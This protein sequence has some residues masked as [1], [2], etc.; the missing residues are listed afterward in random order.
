[1]ADLSLQTTI[2]IEQLYSLLMQLPAKKKLEI[3]RI[4]RAQAVGERWALLSE[5]LPD[6]S[7]E[8]S[9]DEI[10]A[11]VKFVR[12]KRAERKKS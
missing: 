11:E 6:V 12:K 1:M 5:S 7:S 8:I 2:T 9:M 10:I 3:A 4:L